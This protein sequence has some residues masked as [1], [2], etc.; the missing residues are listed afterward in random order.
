MNIPQEFQRFVSAFWQGSR[1]RSPSFEEWID[2]RVSTLEIG[3]K[4]IIRAF[5]DELIAKGSDAELLEAWQSGAP[6]YWFSDLRAFF[7]DVRD[8]LA[9][10]IGR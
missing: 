9:A 6:D 5:L 3:E 1:E 8:R 7:S 4:R 2:D 10:E